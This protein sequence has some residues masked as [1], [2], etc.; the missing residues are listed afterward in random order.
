MSINLQLKTIQQKI[1]SFEQQYQRIPYS[2]KLLA[3]SKGQP[4]EKILE[5]V[6][7][8]QF[9]FAEN[10]LQESLTKIRA[11]DAHCNASP[12]CNKPENSMTKRIALEWHF[13]GPIQSNKTK[14]IA[15]N[16]DWVHTLDRTD[17]ANLLN[18]HRPENLPPLN[19]CIQV[20]IDEEISKSGVSL[21][22][23]S[24]LAH[25]IAALP[26]LKLRGLMTIP[27]PCMIYSTTNNLLENQRQ[28]FNILRSALKNLNNEGLA[29]DTLSMGMSDDYEAAIAEGATLIRIGTAIFG[30]R[31]T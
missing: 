12:P 13:I 10:Y 4:V 1:T 14:L 11:V 27:K 9:A 22:K 18:R 17:I 29:L 8:G 24:S 26:R 19:V 6:A 21:E 25:E 2:V 7:A 23:I 30:E 31:R 15:Q 16:F 5:A 28:P 20:N 3:V